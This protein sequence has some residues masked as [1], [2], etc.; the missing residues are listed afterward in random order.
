MRV[1]KTLLLMLLIGS[2]SCCTPADEPSDNSGNTNGENTEKPKEP[3]V[4]P[5]G[6]VKVHEAPQ[7]LMS[8]VKGT[9]HKVFVEGQECFVFRTE[10]TGGGQEYGQVFP[11]YAFFDYEEE[12]RIT[13]KVTANY[14]V[15]NVAVLPSRYNIIPDVSGNEITFDVTE[16]G[17]YY[18]R[19]GGDD[20][21]GATNDNNLYIFVNP[22][23][24]DIPDKDDP[25][26]KWFRP[27]VYQHKEYELESNKT[28]YLEAG[29]FVYGRF[30]GTNIENVRICGRGTLCGEYLTDMGDPGRTLCIKGYSKNIKVEGV[31]FVHAKVWQVALY[32]CEDVHVDNIHCISHGQSSDGIDITG[33]KNVLVE[34][35]FFRGH[36]DILA[37]KSRVWGV[38]PKM[39]CQNVTFRNCVVWSDSSNPMTIG[40]ETGQNVKNILYE[41]ID[42]LNMSMPPVWQLEAVMAIEPHQQEGEVGYVTDVTYR[43]I[44]VDLKVP[45]NSLFRLSVDDKG[46]ISNVTF[47]DIYVNYG[48]TLGGLLYGD[49]GYMV[50]NITFRNVR[51]SDGATLSMDKIRKN[52]YVG[53]VTL[54]PYVAENTIVGESWDFSTEFSGYSFQQGGNDW[55]Y[56][57]RTTKSSGDMYYEGGNLLG[58]GLWWRKD[59][60]CYIRTFRM[61][62]PDFGSSYT[63]WPKW[64]AGLMSSLD[65]QAALVWKAPATGSVKITGK[66]RKHENRGDGVIVY[67]SINNGNPYMARGLSSST[68][69]TIEFQEY[70]K[71]I[72]KGDEIWFYLD[73]KASTDGD[74]TQIVPRIEYTAVN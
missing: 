26:V 13:I 5:D 1:M 31:N 33:C 72:E 16:P 62:H 34:N 3:V 8:T 19:T 39:D 45:D 32:Q 57:Y 58:G 60:S 12:G 37:V 68:N 10:A 48:G 42:V 52:A 74:F 56:R 63:Y 6:T 49:N 23:E 53:T 7:G 35:S 36:D 4:I 38:G 46:S 18:V 50:D 70:T 11:E 40:Y 65:A 51:N 20:T 14:N 28:Y 30:Y 61:D 21:N 41:K 43:D 47:E 44:R 71:K 67:A 25:N 66:A 27:G 22:K 54:E 55:Y 17:Q 15:S 29:A 2:F 73:P 64:S 24:T 69:T 9:K 59:G